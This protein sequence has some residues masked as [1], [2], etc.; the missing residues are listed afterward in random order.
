ML[1]NIVSP[2]IAVRSKYTRQCVLYNITIDVINTE[3]VSP[4]NDK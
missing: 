1:E 3:N 4:D 2:V